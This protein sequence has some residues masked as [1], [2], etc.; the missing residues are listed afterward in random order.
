MKYNIIIGGKAGQGIDFISDVVSIG[1]IK[2]GY[3][4][5]NYRYYQSL[6]RGG[7][8]YNVIAFSEEK[9]HSFDKKVDFIIALDQKAIDLHR[10][11]L[12]EN[13]YIICDKSLNADKK[14]GFDIRGFLREYNISNRYENAVLVSYFWKL[15]GF[16]KDSLI[17]GFNR[18]KKDE[19]NIK[20]VEKIFNLDIK[21]ILNIN[22]CKMY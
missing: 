15:L 10:E 20:I 16:K 6:I 9:V 4:V 5:F 1:L 2:E 8:N 3:H 17:E 13:G 19:N 14:L 22:S 21:P 12:K 11:K 7:H 18:R